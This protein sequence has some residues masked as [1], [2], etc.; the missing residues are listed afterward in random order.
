MPKVDLAFRI[1]GKSIPADHAY[2]LYSALHE[3]IPGLHPRSDH[4][5]QQIVPSGMP[6]PDGRLW[7]EVGVHPINGRLIG[8]RRLELT[9]RSRLTLRLPD[10][11]IS[12][13]LPLTGK[14]L[15]L[16]SDHLRV[17]A[18]EVRVL[19]PVVRLHARLVVIK[20]FM[21]PKPFLDAVQRQLNEL[22]IRGVPSLLIRRAVKAVE[23]RSSETTHNSTVVRR[24][25]RIRDKE[26][27]GYPVEVANLTAEESI[28][29]QE[30]GLG[31]RRRFGCG[32]YMPASG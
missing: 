12:F 1:I 30:A 3:H 24:T 11:R 27:V 28:R 16:G 8:G 23:G 9:E 32:L 31:G 5:S 19:R 25:L 26:I 20:G 15:Q 21:T 6:T 2:L 7:Q 18:P 13:V 10:A 17:G 4:E 22:E 29:L 14:R